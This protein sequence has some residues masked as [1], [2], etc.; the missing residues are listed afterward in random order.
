MS[1]TTDV[2]AE[3]ALRE[4]QLTLMLAL[5][6]VRD[7]ADDE[8]TL[9]TGATSNLCQAVDADACLLGLSDPDTHALEIRALIDR[10][11]VLD[12]VGEAALRQLI[13]QAAALPSIQSFELDAALSSPGLAHCLAAPI[14]LGEAILG[15]V[16]LANRHQPLSP[17][18]VP[19]M[20]AA[21]SQLDSAL[22]HTRTLRELRDERQELRTLYTIDRI[23]DKGLPFSDMLDAVLAEL[24]RTISSEAGFIMLFDTT[25][26][27]LELRA[28]TDRDLLN[29]ADQYRLVLDAANEAIRQTQLITR[30]R[31][32]G[33]I[34]SLMCVPLILNERIIGVLGVINRREQSEFTRADR[35][36]LGAIASQVDTAIFESLQIQKYREVF[37]RRVG[38]RVM[39]RLLMMT[40]HDFLQGERV[41]VTTLFSDLRGFTAT[42]EI[43]KPNRLVNML[44]DHLSA[45]TDIV[46]SNEGTVDKFVG[47]C[48]MALFNA[49]E[50]QPDHAL[51]AVRTALEMMEVH[52]AL[53]RKWAQ[54]PAIGIGIDTGETIVGNLGSTQRNEYTA[55]SQHVN[56]ASRLCGAAEGGQILIGAATHELVRDLVV[57]E[58]VTGL[59]LK[60]ISEEVTAY[61]VLGLR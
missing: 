4:R 41:I 61:Q 20:M 49:P 1:P 22:M 11:N 12:G 15:V 18:A 35:R 37:G 53:M 21:L 55:I 10:H 44:N 45:M 56:R 54:L 17:H 7:A 6:R 59:K 43:V 47:D 23:R 29:V 48:V 52:H 24:C 42:A 32:S 36:L 57:A 16:V 34:R 13:Q 28:T 38:P 58:Q 26:R 51:R 30:T 8:Y 33:S 14:R 25:G 9:L 5:D 27:Q 39:D 3:L 19:L 2:A 40:E 50:R 31:L 46:L 60:G